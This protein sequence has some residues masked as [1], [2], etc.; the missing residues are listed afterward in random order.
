MNKMTLA[1]AV[2]AALAWWSGAAQAAP[3]PA[4]KC[5][6]AKLSAAG[7]YA[8]CRLAAEKKAV[9]KAI[10]P[11]Y[12]KCDDKYTTA[13]GKAE[14]KYTSACPSSGDQ[15]KVQRRVTGDAGAVTVELGGS[16]PTVLRRLP[17]TG[18]TDSSTAG[19]DGGI[20]AGAALNYVDNGDG[21]ISDVTTDLMWEK[22]VALDFTGD[23]ANLHDA[24]NCY[25]WTGTCAVGGATCSVDGD[26]GA[27]GPCNAVDCQSLPA[28]TG[29]TIFQWVAQV[30]RG[31]GFAGYKD[32]RVPN[33]KELQSIV[34]YGE[35]DPAV[36]RAFN[37][38]SCTTG[39]CADLRSAACSCTHLE[40]YWSSTTDQSD[41]GVAWFVE[42]YTGGVINNGF[43]GTRYYYVRAVRGGL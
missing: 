19:D 11:D 18:Q 34:D 43:K 20:R 42:F 9:L 17:A 2:A 35:D 6:A 26:C 10:P 32:W 37:G 24:D 41:P 7:K 15:S 22:K 5:E 39:G 12:T 4:Q 29:M 25:P 1:V 21:T 38:T 28:A 14:T 27:N 16:S 36:D 31:A 40:I 33:V 23:A 13:W 30:N 3:T 8:A